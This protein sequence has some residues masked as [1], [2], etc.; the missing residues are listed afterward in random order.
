MV[1]I[2]ILNYIITASLGLCAITVQEDLEKRFLLT[3]VNRNMK[4]IRL[5]FISENEA[6]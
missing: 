1:V 6:I 3:I 2:Y 4:Y 5:F